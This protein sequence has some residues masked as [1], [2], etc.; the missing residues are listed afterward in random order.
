MRLDRTKQSSKCLS[1]ANTMRAST[2][3]S[4]LVTLKYLLCLYFTDCEMAVISEV[5]RY[6]SSVGSWTGRK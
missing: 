3:N 4:D 5:E 1:E 2:P 6:D